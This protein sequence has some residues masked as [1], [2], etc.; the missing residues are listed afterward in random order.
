MLVFNMYNMMC[1]DPHSSNHHPNQD[2]KCI[3]HLQG[4]FMPSYVFL[5]FLID[6]SFST[7]WVSLCIFSVTCLFSE[8][9]LPCLLSHF[10]SFS[11]SSSPS[12]FPLSLCH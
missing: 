1:P 7:P 6:L 8:S 9:T 10:L 5:C 12:S 11:P 2:N 4:L 3:H